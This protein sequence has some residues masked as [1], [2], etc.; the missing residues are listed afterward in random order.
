MHARAV[1]ALARLPVMKGVPRAALVDLCLVAPPVRLRKGDLV[2]NAF[3]Y[4]LTPGGFILDSGARALG[5]AVIPAGV[6]NT[7]M[8]IDAISLYL[9][10]LAQ[11]TASG[12]Q[13]IFSLD[14]VAFVQNLVF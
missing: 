10:T 7:E 5:C 1:D 9:L 14:E 6:G 4:H 2:H 11:M 13:I 12:L 8:Q 3:A